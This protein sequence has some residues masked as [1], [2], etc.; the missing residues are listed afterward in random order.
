[1][2]SLD[3]ISRTGRSEANGCAAAFV[4]LAPVALEN[5]ADDRGLLVN[6]P[7]GVPAGFAKPELGE[8]ERNVEPPDLQV[9]TGRPE[10]GLE[11]TI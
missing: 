2:L 9:S 6:T 5:A 3:R 1:M 11:P 10:G 4:E 8:L 7:G